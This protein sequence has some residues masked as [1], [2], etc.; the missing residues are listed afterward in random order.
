MICPSAQIG[1]ITEAGVSDL[2][3]LPG[4][5]HGIPCGLWGFKT[6]VLTFQKEASRQLAC[7][8]FRATGKSFPS[9]PCPPEMLRKEPGETAEKWATLMS[10]TRGALGNG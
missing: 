9:R 3:S 1:N 4:T 5:W 2:A 10:W 6:P 8:T 7:R